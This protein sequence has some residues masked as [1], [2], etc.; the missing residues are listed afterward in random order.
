MREKRDSFHYQY[1]GIPVLDNEQEGKE[2]RL[3]LT[4]SSG[5]FQVKL[6]FVVIL[7]K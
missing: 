1:A 3:I 4:T 7:Y 6:A 5:L 2:K